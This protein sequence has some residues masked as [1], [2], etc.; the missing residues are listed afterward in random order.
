MEALLET[1]MA[2]IGTFQSTVKDIHARI[3]AV[4]ARQNRI[5]R[6]TSSSNGALSAVT[7]LIKD[8]AIPLLAVAVTWLITHEQINNK[9][10]PR[11]LLQSDSHQ[12]NSTGSIGTPSVL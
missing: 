10:I 12:S 2:S 8:F 11:P 6:S 7:G 3:D 5:E 1:M 4:E 9:N